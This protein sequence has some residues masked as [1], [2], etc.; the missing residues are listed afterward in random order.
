M[1]AAQCKC[2]VAVKERPTCG[3]WQLWCKERHRH[4]T[5]HH[6]CGVLPMYT[7]ETEWSVVSIQFLDEQRLALDLSEV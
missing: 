6:V 4:A 5:S 2:V 3:I 7:A 1:L